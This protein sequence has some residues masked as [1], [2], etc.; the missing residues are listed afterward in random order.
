M[1]RTLAD[2]LVSPRLLDAARGVDVEPGGLA[3]TVAGTRYVEG[4]PVALART[5]GGVLYQ[6]V[7]NGRDKPLEF[8]LRSF[9]DPRFEQ[10]LVAATPPL[11]RS[12][13][14]DVVAPAA[15]GATDVVVDLDGVRVRVPNSEPREGSVRVDLPGLRPALSPG[16][17]YAHGPRAGRLRGPVL[18]LY[19]HVADPQAAPEVWRRAVRFL[20]VPEIGWHAKVLS[21]PSLYPRCDAL[22]VYLCRDGWPVAAPLAHELEATGL[23]GGST[24][25]FTRA[26]TPSVGC[27]FEPTDRRPAHAGSSFGQHRANVVAEAVVAHALEGADADLAGLLAQACVDADVDPLEPAR[28]L[29]SPAL[30]VLGLQ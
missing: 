1:T 20:T 29:A 4:S 10:T 5:V 12:V 7:H 17:L 30:P 13:R 6:T 18:R 24:S 15:P 23:L 16:F 25:P 27:A 9:R 22:V 28:N 26:L 11:V 14:A 8:A 21:T 3:A 19:A 2:R